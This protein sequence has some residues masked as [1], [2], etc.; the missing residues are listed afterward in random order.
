MRTPHT[1]SADYILSPHSYPRG[2]GGLQHGRR[3]APLEGPRSVH[4]QVGAWAGGEGSGECKGGRKGG[5]CEKTETV[6]YVAEH[7]LSGS[8]GTRVTLFNQQATIPNSVRPMPIFPQRTIQQTL[9]L[10]LVSGV[11]AEE[12]GGAAE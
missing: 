6:P 4:N 8:T 7:A 10:P 5:G 11:A 12:G 1:T 2:D 3:S 9:D